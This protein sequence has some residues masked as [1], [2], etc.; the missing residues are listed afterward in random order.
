MHKKA[1]RK[2][3]LRDS[4]L[5]GWKV[6]RERVFKQLGYSRLMNP[7]LTSDCANVSI[8]ELRLTSICLHAKNAAL[9]I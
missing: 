9:I 1:P 2:C 4:T 6:A 3:V 8:F 5:N 7:L